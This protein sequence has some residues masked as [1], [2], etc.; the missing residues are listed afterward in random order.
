MKG[1]W[2]PVGRKTLAWTFGKVINRLVGASQISV[3]AQS[4]AV[5]LV[6]PSGDIRGRRAILSCSLSE[7]STWLA[8][9]REDG[10]G[11]DI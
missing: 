1:R 11:K 10:L 5:D 6:L 9:M 4:H 3:L 7:S 2:V 8:A